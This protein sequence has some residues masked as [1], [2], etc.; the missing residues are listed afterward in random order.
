[1]SKINKPLM[2]M[3][4][5]TLIEQLQSRVWDKYKE[6]KNGD[7]QEW[8]EGLNPIEKAAWKTKFNK[9]QENEN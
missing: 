4:N 2:F 9:L 7:F 3:N 1:M 6:V 8:Y 5:N